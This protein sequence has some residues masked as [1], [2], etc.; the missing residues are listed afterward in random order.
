[1]ILRFFVTTPGSLMAGAALL[2]IPFLSPG[3]EKTTKGEEKEQSEIL[4]DFSGKAPGEKWVTVNDNVMGG[5]SK[6]G[7]SF[8]GDKLVFAGSTNTNGGG[9]SSVRSKATDLDLGNKDGVIIR[10]KGDGRT[11]K[12]GVRMARSSAAYR[13]DF[14]SSGD[15][16]GWQV[17]KIPFSSLAPSWRGTKLSLKRYPLKKER[18]ESIGLMIYDKKDGPFRLQVDWI[19]TYSEM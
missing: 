14:K 9:F 17:V 5:R 13:A 6:G 19:R 3:A 2:L 4:F 10:F 16:R 8:K 18:I 15:G 7:F 12:F 1:M 11:Y